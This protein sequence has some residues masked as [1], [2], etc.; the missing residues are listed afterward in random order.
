MGL[1][2]NIGSPAG[3]LN[4]F[5]SN[6]IPDSFGLFMC[7]AYPG[8][9]GQADGAQSGTALGEIEFDTVDNLMNSPLVA[10]ASNAS[11]ASSFGW[12]KVF[13]QGTPWYAVS[14]VKVSVT[15]SLDTS[16]VYG[17]S[18][19]KNLQSTDYN[20]I[21]DSGTGAATVLH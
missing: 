20:T 17:S 5:K 3:A 6:G 21:M 4:Q 10:N 19:I 15:D 16:K 7:Q 2:Y 8:A 18:N 1:G 11:N 12:I 14:M 9:S 13:P